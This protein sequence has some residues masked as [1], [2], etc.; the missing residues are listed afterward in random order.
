MANIL[1]VYNRLFDESMN[2]TIGGIQNYLIVLGKCLSSEGHCVSYLNLGSESNDSKCYKTFNVTNS[3]LKYGRNNR[4]R[5]RKLVNECT[6]YNSIII[7]GSD[8]MRTYCK[9]RVNT[10]IQHGIGFDLIP[11]DK[12]IRKIIYKYFGYKF[13]K[14]LQ[15]YNALKNF[16]TS[17]V[18][19][20]VDYNFL[21]WYRTFSNRRDEKNTHVITNFADISESNLDL[22]RKYTA[23]CST[24]VFARRFVEKRGVAIMA[25]SV[26]RIASTF[27]QTTFYFCGEGPLQYLVDDLCT[28]HPNVI[29]ERYAVGKGVQYHEDKSIAVIPTLGSEGTSFSLLEAMSAGCAVI[30]TNVGGMT[31]ILLDNFNG[32]IVMPEKNDVEKALVSLLEDPTRASLL[33]KNARKTAQAAFS[34]ERW[35]NQWNNVIKQSNEI[36]AKKN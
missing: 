22:D 27:P 35:S 15:R 26:D 2:P 32:L 14:S 17:D 25:S 31:N 1:I 23:S 13:A 30:A 7:W 10:V 34:L 20:C 28:K 24:V 36:L 3:E 21:N 18:R 9:N 19:V 5:V 6:E 11:D 8:S 33:G 29:S 4:R 16:R 12:G